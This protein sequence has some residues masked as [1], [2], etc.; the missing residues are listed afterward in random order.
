MQKILIVGGAG[1]I[2]SNLA[3]ELVLRGNEVI[4][5][6]DFSNGDYYL[7]NL[8]HKIKIKNCDITKKDVLDVFAKEL[9]EIVVHLA[10]QISVKKSIADPVYDEDV[11]VKGTI[12]VL[13]GCVQA[14]VKKILYSSS[15]A[16]YGNPQYL[17]IDEKHEVN[18][19]SFYGVSKY[20]AE[21]YVKAY[22]NIYG[23]KYAILRLA[24]VYGPGQCINTYSGVIPLF[25]QSMLANKEP[26]IFGDG[27][28]TRDFVYIKDVVKAFILAMKYSDNILLNIGAGKP[29]PIL[30]LFNY[31][32]ELINFQL[33]P[34]FLE[35]KKGDIIESYFNSQS[36]FEKLNWEAEYSTKD[37][38]K[39][40][41]KDSKDVKCNI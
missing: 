41:V 9:P 22:Y 35:A 30:D 32:S 26:I 6:D 34:L 3:N 11:N 39:E 15:A 23:L 18:P 19:I 40:I 8:N 38:L 14:N 21:L 10:A 7:K 29:T 13:E 5:I 1:F 33:S 27:K 31:L 4:V 16:I 24:N 12:N 25:L 37:G 2:G 20:S 28:Q 36:A 17:G